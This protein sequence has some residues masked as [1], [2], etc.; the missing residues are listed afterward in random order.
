M[1]LLCDDPLTTS[2]SVSN[3][4]L[5]SA[6]MRKASCNLLARLLVVVCVTGEEV[7]DGSSSRSCC[8]RS[9][10]PRDGREFI[11]PP[12]SAMVVRLPPPLNHLPAPSFVT[13]TLSL[14]LLC[15][16][17]EHILK[18]VG[19]DDGK[20]NVSQRKTVHNRKMVRLR[21]PSIRRWIGFFVRVRW[22]SN[23]SRR[24][25]RQTRR[26]GGRGKR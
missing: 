10:A 2:A 18:W 15:F 6:T 24:T 21:F 14:S 22:K 5:S 17:L 8:R 26:S 13:E 25:I 7:D 19:Q 9:L 11:P 20:S 4:P 23:V 12:P 16:G 3:P 1:A